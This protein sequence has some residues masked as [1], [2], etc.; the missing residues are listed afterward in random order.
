MTAPRQPCDCGERLGGKKWQ[1]EL[2][3]SASAYSRRG[4]EERSE[5]NE[6]VVRIWTIFFTH[7]I[8]AVL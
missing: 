3:V 7:L 5:S 1:W 8:G 2:S 4:R 6:K